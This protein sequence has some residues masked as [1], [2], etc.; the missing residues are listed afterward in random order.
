MTNAT[1]PH[2]HSEWSEESFF[3]LRIGSGRNL[4]VLVILKLF[5]NPVFQMGLRPRPRYAFQ[6]EHLFARTKR[7]Q[8]CALWLLHFLP[9][10]V[11]LGKFK[12]LPSVRHFWIYNPPIPSHAGT[13]QMGFT[14]KSFPLVGNQ[15][16][17]HPPGSRVALS[18]IVRLNRTMTSVIACRP[19][20]N[21]WN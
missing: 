9:V 7:C 5:Q 6:A 20:T 1:Q 15:T 18:W 2:C 3:S 21:Y 17:C 19:E 12:K 13:N 14:K 4:V 8:K 10:S 16:I 11:M